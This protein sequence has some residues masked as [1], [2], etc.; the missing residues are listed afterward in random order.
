MLLQERNPQLHEFVPRSFANSE[1]INIFIGGLTMKPIVI[2][3]LLVGVGL[4]IGCQPR[5]PVQEATAKLK[6][7]VDAYVHAWNTG[8]LDTLS[9]IC[10]PQVVAYVGT[11]SAYRGLDSLKRFITGTR[12]MYPDFKVTV[13]EE[14][15]V[16]NHAVTRWIITGTNTVPG[17]FPPTGKSFKVSGL[18][19][20][21]FVNGKLAE[22]CME[23]DR[24]YLEQQ[25]GFKLTPPTK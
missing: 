10:D 12:T 23:Y 14:L 6:P 8:K 19:L 16:G 20:S 17:D 15:Y 24:L 5:D 4:L 22:E 7:V 18:S 25:L 21:R 1:A 3:I 9:A 13:E 11:T 2:L